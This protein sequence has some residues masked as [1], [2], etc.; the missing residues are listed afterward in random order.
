MITSEQERAFRKEGFFHLGP[1]FSDTELEE[2][3]KE[4]DRCLT[5]PMQLAERD[6][7]P[8]LYGPLLQL[9][10]PVLRRYATS[11]SL[12]AVAVDLLGPDIRLYWDQGVFKPVGAESDVPWHQDNG[13]TPVEPE[14]YV[15]FTVAIDATSRDNGC[16]WIQPGSHL[17]GVRPHAPD[18]PFFFR[19]EAGED[20]GVPCEQPEGDVLAFSSLT[21]HRSGP[22]TSGRPRRSWIIQLCR[23]DTRHGVTKK[24]MDDRLWVAK[25]GEPVAEPWSERPF[26]VQALLESAKH[27]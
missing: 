25:G 16:L 5:R 9:Q 11:P 12:A 17:R 6:K 18:G 8:F 1:I 20:P 22:N 7:S 27:R 21:M 14:E 19:G 15:T 3:R 4:Y 23:A 26:D 13:Y 2:I 10:S 24:R